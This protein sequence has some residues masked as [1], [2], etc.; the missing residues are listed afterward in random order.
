[1]RGDP[2]PENKHAV[3]VKGTQARIGRPDPRW[4]CS[5]VSARYR[6][7]APPRPG[8][9]F[10][11]RFL[12]ASDGR[13]RQSGHGPHGRFQG[14]QALPLRDPR[15]DHG[16][17]PSEKRGRVPGRGV[18]VRI[19]E[20][21]Q[22]LIGQAHGPMGMGRR[23]QGR[24]GM[25]GVGGDDEDPAHGNLQEHSG[26]VHAPPPPLGQA[27]DPPLMGVPDA[28][29]S[30]PRAATVRHAPGL[31]LEPHRPPVRHARPPRGFTSG[32]G[33]LRNEHE[34]RLPPSPRAGS[35]LG[36]RPPPRGDTPPPGRR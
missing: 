9:R 28:F 24:A 33:K 36:S 7:P 18:R 11:F 31:P 10:F 2:E 12:T 15:V 1:M 35:L 3:Q 34:P 22:G 5:G 16:E 27:E 26:H 25:R 21:P 32:P 30:H 29:R 20:H 23:S 13:P 4:G 19:E 14:L 17:V 8:G 6:A